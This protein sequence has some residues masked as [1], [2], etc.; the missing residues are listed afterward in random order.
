MTA[1]AL[2]R[3]LILT[4][5]TLGAF[6]LAQSAVSA[7]TV[8]SGD[9][10]SALAT[11]HNT[12]VEKVAMENHIKDVNLIYVGQTLNF[13]EAQATEVKSA[14]TY[15]VQ[16]GDTLNKIGKKV[17]LPVTKLVSLNGIA[18][19]DI[20]SVGQVLSLT[21]VN[22]VVTPAPVQETQKTV[23]APVQT[24]VQAPVQ[25]PV[26][27]TQKT[28]QDTPAPK[29][30]DYTSTSY[31]VAQGD[32]FWKIAVANGT[33]VQSLLAVN[34]LTPN[35]TIL[36]GQTL[37]IARGQVEQPVQAPVQKSVEQ[38]VQTPVQRQAPVQAPVQQ[39]APVQRQAPVSG[40]NSYPAGQCTY[41]VKSVLSWVPN[42][43]GNATDWL[44]TGASAGHTINQTATAGSVAIFRAGTA[45]ADPTYGHVAVVDSV[46]ANGTI[47]I[48]ESNYAG[49]A[50]HTR[51]ISTAGVWFMHQ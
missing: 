33:T 29:A 12:T 51:T 44:F 7:D 10:L 1:T 42:Y 50:Y 46:N 11:A 8:K 21:G 2:R 24:P 43:L 26:Q 34:G 36:V 20:I 31:T 9:T 32:S 48:S 45:G 13:G 15:T 17:N 4:A 35:D 38:P 47:N 22:K 40:F 19:P 28:V 5:T 30:V 18:N 25:T 41:Y 37:K 14:T 6:G 27:E 49:L 39:Q 3:N 16:S 23:Q